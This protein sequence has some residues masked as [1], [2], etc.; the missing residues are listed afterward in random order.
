MAKD[1]VNTLSQL[2]IPHQARCA[3]AESCTGGL[4]A[5]ELTAY[6]GSSAWFDCGI[7]AYSNDAK[8]RLLNVP[9]TILDTHGA[10]SAE[11]VTAMAENLVLQP[12]IHLTMAVSGIAGPDGSNANQ[13]VGTVWFAWATQQESHTT[14]HQLTGSRTD[15]RQQCVHIALNG[16]IKCA[17]QL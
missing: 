1:L 11:T 7:V 15:I 13:P 14:L 12:H 5:A 6:P 4:I 8:Q 16:L 10:V 9:S 2:L 3:V 17:Q